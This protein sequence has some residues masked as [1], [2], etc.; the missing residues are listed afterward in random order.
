MFQM[1]LNKL[2][3]FYIVAKEG[4]IKA[5]SKKLNLT[6]P[7]ISSQIKEFEDEIELQLFHRE[8]RKLTLT[9]KG[10]F[11]LEKAEEIFKLTNELSSDILREHTA[12]RT[13]IKIGALNNLSSLLIYDFSL[14]LWK[15]ES[16]RVSVQQGSQRHLLDLLHSND[17]DMVLT[18]TPVQRNSSYKSMLL[19]SDR[20]VAVADPDFS[21]LRRKFP[22][23]LNQ[24][25]YLAF[26]NQS[27]IQEDINNFLSMKK[28][29]PQK[30]GE[31][32]DISLMRVIT[33]NTACFSIL[34][35]R[36]VKQSIQL[37]K[38][39]VVGELE[40]VKTQLWVITSKV[41]N[42]KKL[43]E[44]IIQDYFQRKK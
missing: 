36:S 29:Q 10:L 40:E 19:N 21:K 12:T 38:L 33:E 22:D 34:P 25:P 1:N 18:D 24:V 35:Y 8:H 26:S 2:Y 23:S 27:R 37:G 9:K 11:L 43:I 15:D 17:L 30:I 5:A 32:D 31:V 20:I 28:L 13:L 3:Y 4:S 14:K 41:S 16:I 7:T 42:K 39:S 6:S 44:K